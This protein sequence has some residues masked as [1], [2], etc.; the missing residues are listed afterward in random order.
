MNMNN[1]EQSVSILIHGSLASLLPVFLPL[2]DLSFS[3]GWRLWRYW[4]GGR[5]WLSWWSYWEVKRKKKPFIFQLK[6]QGQ[7]PTFNK[8]IFSKSE[9]QTWGE[10]QDCDWTWNIQTGQEANLYFCQTNK[11]TNK[12][13]NGKEQM[14]KEE[15]K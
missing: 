4:W 15:K 1:V 6:K 9:E 7:L 3:W 5:G 10:L 12:Q 14:V 2:F 13:R 11:E 8:N